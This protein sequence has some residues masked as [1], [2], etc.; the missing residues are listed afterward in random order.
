MPCLPQTSFGSDTRRR[1]KGYFPVGI[2]ASMLT[3]EDGESTVVTSL[4]TVSLGD[5][6]DRYEGGKNAD[7]P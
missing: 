7:S 1:L 3:I 2:A 6:E 5:D 4:N